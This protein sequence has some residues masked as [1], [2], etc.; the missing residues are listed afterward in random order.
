MVLLPL[1]LAALA[2]SPGDTR[3]ARQLAHRSIVEY[4]VGDFDRALADATKAYELDS[5]PAFLYN[6]GQCHRALH[7]WERAGFFF[8]GYLRENPAASNRAA[9]EALIAA[10]DASRRKEE[11]AAERAQGPAPATVLP[12]PAPL[13]L[14]MRSASAV[15]ASQLEVESRRSAVPEAAVSAGPPPRHVPAAAWVTLGGG[16][17]AAL[18]GGVVWGLASG[19]RLGYSGSG[20]TPTGVTYGQL[21]QSNGLAVAGDVLVPLGVA[22]LAGGAVWAGWG[23]QADPV[24]GP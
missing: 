17:A 15:P 4:N 5:R 22:L 21:Q 23:G 8:R 7:H 2:A 14:P 6:L 24:K 9:V 20:K 13:E 11:A 16:V 12:L 18:A 10:M 3:E 19:D 1:L